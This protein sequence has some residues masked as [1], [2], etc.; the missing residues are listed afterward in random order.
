M[1]CEAENRM[2]GNNYNN[3]LENAA[4]LCLGSPKYKLEI[5]KDIEPDL[6]AKY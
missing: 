3:F 2:P 1:Q 4:T 5:F 6:L